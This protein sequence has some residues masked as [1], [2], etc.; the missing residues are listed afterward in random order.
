M[1][2]WTQ[3]YAGLIVAAGLVTFV[4]VA[5]AVRVELRLPLLVFNVF[6]LVTSLIG[7]SLLGFDLM[8]TVWAL[9]QP[10]MDAKNVEPGQSLG[11]WAI[12]WGPLT[13]TNLAAYLSRNLWRR[14]AIFVARELRMTIDPVT[15]AIV[16][17]ALTAYALANLYAHDAL[18][19]GF[20]QSGNTGD[21]TAN[22][23]ARTRL[24]ALL[25]DFH[26]AVLYMMLPA[27]AVAALNTAAATRR[28]SAWLLFALLAV[29]LVFLYLTTYTKSNLLIMSI[30][31]V[32]AAW[33]NGLVRV[34]GIVLAALGGFAALTLLEFLQ[35]GDA[36]SVLVRSAF[37]LVFRMASGVPFYLAVFP[38]QLPYPGVDLGLQ[39]FGIGP[40]VPVNL[41]VADRMFPTDLIVQGAVPA[42][43]HIAAYALAG[44]WWSF[45]TMIFVGLFLSA[46]A[47]IGR[48][49]NNLLMQSAFVGGCVSSYYM[50]QVDFVGAFLAGYGLRWWLIGLGA[51]WLVQRL[52][53]AAIPG[54][55]TTPAQRPLPASE[56][57]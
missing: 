9:M 27:V 21:Y 12:T 7:T 26:F 8:R 50:T 22:I 30:G 47:S 35:A 28:A 46:V 52:L 53:E 34:R 54:A 36:S 48:F 4:A 5:R 38:D 20:L 33:S 55:D 51:L 17:A 37:N 49:R 18:S 31:F 45:A 16:G 11:Y 40:T 19:L 2:D 25:G 24:F 15:C 29:I 23:I 44:P 39:T 6:Y 56:T 32:V 14:P 13:V 3:F 57:R 43:A 10:T 1:S 42:P 41:L